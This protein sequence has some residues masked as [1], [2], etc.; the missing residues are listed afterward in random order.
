M[1][2]MPGFARTAAKKCRNMEGCAL[3][4]SHPSF[5]YTCG[6]MKEKVMCYIIEDRNHS[7]DT[8]VKDEDQRLA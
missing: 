5:F 6:I 3:K 7:K 4:E 2:K 1:K 8:G